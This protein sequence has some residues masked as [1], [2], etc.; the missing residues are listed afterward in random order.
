MAPGIFVRAQGIL[1]FLGFVVCFTIFINLYRSPKIV[2][3]NVV[4]RARL[5]S[6]SIETTQVMSVIDSTQNLAPQFKMSESFQCTDQALWGNNHAGG[7]I[8]CLDAGVFTRKD[9]LNNVPEDKCIVYSFGLGADWSFDNAAEARGCEVHGFDPTGLLWRQGMHGTAYANIDYAKQYPSKSKHFH[10]WGVGAADIAVYPAGS[11][12]QDWPGLGDPQLSRSNPE[13]WEMRSIARTMQDLGHDH[14]TVLKVDVEGAEWDAMA[15]LLSTEK[16]VSM[17]R[18]GRIRQL[19][20]EWHW[21]PDSRAKNARHATIMSRI[22]DL[23][24]KPW[25]ITRHEGSDCCLDISYI[26]KSISTPESLSVINVAAVDKKLATSPG[27]LADVF[28]KADDDY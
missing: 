8:V 9:P 17:V 18:E 11:V 2:R 22:E 10:N 24:F 26:W 28:R 27:I 19:L 1:Y 3:G 21:D 23:G 14:L 7:W 16:M 4:V 13:P 15:A 5:P 20:V 12:P 25:K 6:E